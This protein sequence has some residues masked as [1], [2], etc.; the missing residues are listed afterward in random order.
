MDERWGNDKEESCGTAPSDIS[1]ESLTTTCLLHSTVYSFLI[2]FI[3]MKGVHDLENVLRKTV[4]LIV[5]T[6]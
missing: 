5:L 3:S 2:L 1:C 4:R 6:E